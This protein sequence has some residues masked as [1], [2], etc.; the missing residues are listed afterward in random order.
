MAWSSDELAKIVEADDLKIAPLRDDG[1]TYGTPTW[2][3]CVAVDGALYVRAYNG[4][5]SRW[6]QA[7]SRERGG[8][9]HAAGMVRE[10]R[11]E[12]VEGE[13]LDRIDEAY[14]TKYRGSQYLEPL[15]SARA[16]AAC[17]K[18]VPVEDE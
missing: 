7:A 4:R 3:W 14:R 15:V 2:I 13:I 18:I 1:V 12:L 5:A 17:V 8:R 9:I 6:Y 10:V 11:F 16:R